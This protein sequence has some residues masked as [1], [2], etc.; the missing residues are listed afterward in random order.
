M[1]KPAAVFIILCILG[2]SAW[3]GRVDW[4]EGGAWT[5]NHK[6]MDTTTSAAAADAFNA[7]QRWFDALERTDAE[8]H[9]DLGGITV[10]AYGDPEKRRE[11]W[12]GRKREI[13]WEAF[14]DTGA[15]HQGQKM[16]SVTIGQSVSSRIPEIWLDLRKAKNGGL[17]LPPHVLGHE[18]IHTLRIKDRRIQDPDQLVAVAAYEWK[19]AEKG[20]GEQAGRAVG[21]APG[22]DNR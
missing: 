2:F 19:F 7:Y 18:F 22:R 11:A 13:D 16:G 1:K 4:L 9:V 17:I 5:K 8:L 14:F 20:N 6:K 12:D 21:A 3:A 10:H 15:Q